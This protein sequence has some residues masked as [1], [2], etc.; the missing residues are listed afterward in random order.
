M[1]VN[2][3]NL[4]FAAKVSSYFC[5]RIQFNGFAFKTSLNIKLIE[6]FYC[7]ELGVDGD[8]GLVFN[9]DMASRLSNVIIGY[10]VNDLAKGYLIA[11]QLLRID[12]NL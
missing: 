8:T 2:L 5:N 1:S 11:N 3:D 12:I 4:F 10:F 6:F 7:I 9:F